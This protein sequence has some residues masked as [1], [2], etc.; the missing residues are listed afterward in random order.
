MIFTGRVSTI[1]ELQNISGLV[2]ITG[3][4]EERDLKSTDRIAEAVVSPS[5]PLIGTTIRDSNFR[6]RYRASIL[7]VHRNGERID[8]KIGDIV[9]RPG[10]TLL[11]LTSTAFERSW[12]HSRDFYLVS[13]LPSSVV[14]ATK[15]KPI[16][17]G[18]MA[19]MITVATLGPYLPKTGGN[20]IDM[21]VCVFGA[22]VLMILTRCISPK[23]ARESI[24]LNV[25]LLIACAFG[26]AVALEKTGVAAFIADGIIALFSPFGKVGVLSGMYL[27][28][29]VFS[30]IITNNATAA[31]I[32][33]IAYATAVHISVDPRP[34]AIAVAIAAS[35]SFATPIAYQT[36]MIVYGP[37]GYRFS[38]YL[39]TGIPLNILLWIVSMIVIPLFWPF[40]L[41][42]H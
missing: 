24:E 2:H 9:L 20:S 3:P 34:F 28:T 11:L 27:V 6:T 13:E 41:L 40:E 30:A 32:F 42:Q 8:S 15:K 21:F 29:I 38:D 19:L 25:L 39:K 37:G 4:D 14:V 7:A 35:A 31:L 36:N 1:R 26:I 23:E 33:P 10:D 18:I 5:S 17:L 22:A 12:A 16:A